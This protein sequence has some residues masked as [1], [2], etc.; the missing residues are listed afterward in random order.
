MDLQEFVAHFAEQFEE[1]DASVF[2]PQTKYHELLW[3]MKNT[4]SQAKVMMLR[5]LSLLRICLT[6][7]KNVHNGISSI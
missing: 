6:L 1:T 7:L 3:V 4:M 2:T 5:V